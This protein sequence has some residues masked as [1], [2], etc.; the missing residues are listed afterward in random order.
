[1]QAVVMDRITQESPLIEVHTYFDCGPRSF[2]VDIT[3]K[4]NEPLFSPGDAVAIDPDVL[5]R[6]GDM[7]LA[8]MKPEER[9]VF[10]RYQARTAP[11][12]TKFVE[13]APLNATWDTDVIHSDADGRIIGVMTEHVTPRR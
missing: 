6:P 12:G 11:T 3:D 10:R 5:P 1:M 9:P 7:V 2:V 4:S 13:L 8:V